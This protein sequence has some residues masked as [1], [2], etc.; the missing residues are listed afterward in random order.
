MDPAAFYTAA[1]RDTLWADAPPAFVAAE[2]VPLRVLPVRWVALALEALS[3]APGDRALDL[4]P[5]TGYFGALLKHI[6]GAPG[7]V[8]V[9]TGDATRPKS[10]KGPFDAILLGGGALPAWPRGLPR[11]MHPQGGRAVAFLGPAF[12]RRTWSASSGTVRARP[13]AWTSA[14][15]PA[16]GCRRS[17]RPRGGCE[18]RRP[19]TE[20]VA[21][22][23][24][25][26][27]SSRPCPPPP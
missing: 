6:V 24:A 5:A 17:L 8:V 11:Y 9:T 23:G 1:E 4:A 15:S 3:L 22:R 12:A 27:L 16:C 26:A 13:P 14:C 21:A 20:A 2:G 7:E 10:L 18:G 19:E 25:L